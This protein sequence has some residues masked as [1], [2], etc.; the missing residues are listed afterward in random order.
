MA[1]HRDCVELTAEM[2]Q[3]WLLNVMDRE[4][5]LFELFDK[6]WRHPRVDHLIRAKHDRTLEGEPRNLFAAVRQAPVVAR[7]QVPIP[8]Q[9]ARPKRAKQQARPQRLARTV[10]LAVSPQAVQLRPP[11]YHAEEAHPPPEAARAG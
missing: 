10:T 6:Q 3:T 9:S 5:D 4:A 2:L 8:R 7:A 11:S 1:A